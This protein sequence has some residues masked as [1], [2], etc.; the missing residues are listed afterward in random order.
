MNYTNSDRFGTTG[1]GVTISRRDFTRAAAGVLA[2]TVMPAA[3]HQGARPRPSPSQL[4]W[5]E[6]ELA[7]F[8]HFGVNTFTD[9]EW[10]DG[11]EEPAVFDPTRPDP[12]QW[13]RAPKAGRAPPLILTAN[14]H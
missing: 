12:R 13:A 4:A 10:G 3:L 1:A 7:V 9:R 8:L 6:E 11:R 5:Q 2:G 14:Q